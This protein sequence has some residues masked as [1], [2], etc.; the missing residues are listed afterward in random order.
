LPNISHR[1][2]KQ[3]SVEE[4]RAAIKANGELSDA[5]ERFREYLRE[6]G[7][8]LGATPATLGPWVTY[9]LKQEQ[10]VG[11]FAKRANALSKRDYRKPFV[12]P[13]LA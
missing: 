13:K 11:D 8:D 5:F 10:F 2:G 3:A 6:N 12:V 7:V 4:T 9:D 1:L